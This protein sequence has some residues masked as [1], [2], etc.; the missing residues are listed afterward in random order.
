MNSEHSH[1][2]LHPSAAS[3][4]MVHSDSHV[5]AVAHAAMRNIPGAAERID[6]HFS[7]GVWKIP[8]SIPPTPVVNLPYHL[9]W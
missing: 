4:A 7:R 8:Y 9:G 3:E 6:A 5:K 1:L 2:N